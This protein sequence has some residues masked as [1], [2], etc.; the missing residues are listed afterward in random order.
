MSASLVCG[1]VDAGA[2]EL[3]V[4]VLPPAT[5]SYSNTLATPRKRLY[6]ILG[7]NVVLLTLSLLSG[8]ASLLFFRGLIKPREN[9]FYQLNIDT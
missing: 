6:S 7:N 5:T 8:T 1:I 9:V 4:F 2:Y 3:V